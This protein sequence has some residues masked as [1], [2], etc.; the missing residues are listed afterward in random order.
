[1]Q[2]HS[3][4]RPQVK[5]ADVLRYSTKVVVVFEVEFWALCKL[6]LVLLGG[7]DQ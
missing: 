1:M 4:D 2:Q 5:L 7:L 6:L 3:K